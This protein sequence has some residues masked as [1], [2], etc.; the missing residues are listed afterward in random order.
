MDQETNCSIRAAMEC[1][2]Q[3]FWKTTIPP[4]AC[5]ILARKRPT[6]EAVAA[7]CATAILRASL[8]WPRRSPS[9][10]ANRWNRLPG[11]LATVKYVK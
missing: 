8:I 9:W 2:K 7:Y 4:E 1:Q 3:S 11:A 10:N 6:R 5:S